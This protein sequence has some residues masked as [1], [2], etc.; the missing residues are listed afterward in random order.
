VMVAFQPPEMIAVPL[1][2]AASGIK[3]VPLDGDTLLTCRD[4][5]IALGD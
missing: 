2:D 3:R 4:L 5:G 1:S